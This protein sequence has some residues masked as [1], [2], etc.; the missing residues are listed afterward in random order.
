MEVPVDSPLKALTN[1]IVF[2]QYGA[3]DLPSQYSARDLP[4]QLSGGDLDGDIYNVIWDPSL[5]PTETCA[6]ADYPRVAPQELNRAVTT[7]DMSDFLITF[8]ESD[9]LGMISN[10]HLSVSDQEDEGTRHPDCIQLANMASIAVDFPKTGIP[11]DMRQCPKHN[12]CRP[13]FMAPSPRVIVS[14]AGFLGFEDDDDQD[15]EAFEG[16]DAERR[17]YQYYASDKA[18]GHLYRAIDERQ[19]LDSMQHQ[20]RIAAT[21]I[22]SSSILFRLLGYMQKWATNYGIIYTHQLPVAREIR[23]SYEDNL[24]DLL[25]EFGPSVLQP[26]SGPKSSR[27]R[28]SVARTARKAGPSASSQRKCASGSRWSSTTP[29]RV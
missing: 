4:S 27:A 23:A 19:F 21:T 6:P 9:V 25:Y 10:I 16:M 14:T 22:T 7:K 17:P 1:V 20:Q 24:L 2:S 26:V 11:V 12:R 28:S 3:W 5:I 18:L 8:L 29:S 13:D 15:D